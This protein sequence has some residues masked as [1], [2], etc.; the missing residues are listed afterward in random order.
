[1]S[2][3]SP[4]LLPLARRA[5]ELVSGNRHKISHWLF[6]TATTGEL[7]AKLDALPACGLRERRLL[8]SPMKIIIPGGW[9]G[10][11]TSDE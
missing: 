7:R 9:R 6:H 11:M 5:C 8:H 2:N 10:K 3:D 4:A 1:L